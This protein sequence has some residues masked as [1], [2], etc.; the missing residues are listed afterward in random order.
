MSLVELE[1]ELETPLFMGGHDL[2][3]LD[4]TWFL[5][6]SAVKGIWRWWARALVA[7]ALYD[8]GELKG[9]RGQGILKVPSPEEA[10]KISETVGKKMGLGYAD[11]QGKLSRAS[12]YLL[13]VESVNADEFASSRFR[14]WEGQQMEQL[15]RV[16]L[17]TLSRERKRKELE[18]LTSGA[19]FRLMIEERLPVGHKEAEAALSA[20]SLALTFSG[21]GKG[22]R[23]GLGCLRVIGA[24][25][26][27]AELFDP[28]VP[29]VERLRCAIGAA[30]RLLGIKA[31]EDSAR[32]LPPLPVISTKRLAVSRAIRGCDLRPFQVLKVSGDSPGQLLRDLHNFFLR[33][34]RV[35]RLF[36]DY[37]AEDHLR[38]RLD[39]WVLGLPRKQKQWLKIEDPKKEGGQR[40]KVQ[41]VEVELGYFIKGEGIERRASPLMLAVHGNVAYLSIFVSAD[42]PAR[43]EW[44][45]EPKVK[46]DKEAK[47]EIKTE[48]IELDEMRIVGA[49]ANALEELIDYV[50]KCKLTVSFI[51]P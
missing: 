2:S 21:F 28:K 36:G 9:V 1:L 23:R 41:E 30:R 25:G 50:E 6:P 38:K 29:E 3:K 5:R 40:Q 42:W 4:E 10:S 13:V 26:R 47:L 32:E 34:V 48:S 22:C 14:G 19:R 18:H 45:G 15:Q 12:D 33:G 37:K 20:L 17:L 49:M 31:I 27:Y 7:G 51:C 24:C 44:R 35:R 16:S 46:K 8:A 11:P 43:L 39:A